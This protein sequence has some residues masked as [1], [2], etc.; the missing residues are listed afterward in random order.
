MCVGNSAVA[1]EVAVEGVFSPGPEGYTDPRSAVPGVNAAS[2]GA[3]PSDSELTAEPFPVSRR[4]GTARPAVAVLFAGLLCGWWSVSFRTHNDT[5]VSPLE[6]IGLALPGLVAGLVLLRIRPPVL[7]TAK[8][9]GWLAA[10]GVA[11]YWVPT[12][13]M[14]VAVS[15][16][17]WTRSTRSGRDL[18]TP[19]CAA[20]IGIISFQVMFATYRGLLDERYVTLAYVAMVADAC[21]VAIIGWCLATGRSTSPALPRG[22]L[23][24]RA[25]VAL[26]GLALFAATSPV[27][28]GYTE[29]L[30]LYFPYHPYL[31]IV[32]VVDP[33]GTGNRHGRVVRV[34][35]PAPSLGGQG[36]SALIYLPPGYDA[37]KTWRYPVLY[38]LHGAPGSPEDWLVAGQV[39]RVEDELVAEKL[40]PATILVMPDGTGDTFADS[41]WINRPDGTSNVADFVS[42]DLVTYIDSHYRT[43]SDRSGRILGGLSEGGFGAVNIG[44]KDSAEYSVILSMSGYYHPNAAA[45]V[46]G[47]DQAGID[48]NDPF[49]FIPTLAI[50]KP[51][52]VYMMRAASDTKFGP[53]ADEMAHLLTAHDI[54]YKLD[55]FSG[56]HTWLFWNK[57]MRDAF[58]A[59]APHIPAPNGG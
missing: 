4:R 26:T 28:E 37:H 56:F 52:F 9:I 45:G 2:A 40:M 10:I 11:A 21:A 22:R 15:G 3:T 49:R 25:A 23:R 42:K 34:S 6:T 50:Q 57:H 20:V 31:D 35:V 33:I 24:R 27:V 29:G 7:L 13:P 51:M 30:I 17:L 53:Q 41:E 36:R 55:T 18:S 48:A 32:S 19:F 44:L 1:N 38:L 58:L 43:I 8:R 54:P 14:I 59:V 5:D 47:H 12:I 39:D 46:Y 16:A